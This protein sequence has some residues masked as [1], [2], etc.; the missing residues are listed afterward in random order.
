M[1]GL[2]RAAPTR[3][4][5]RARRPAPGR[6]AVRHQFQILMVAVAAPPGLLRPRRDRPP[7]HH[8]RDRRDSAR[9][10]VDRL[11]PCPRRAPAGPSPRGGGDHRHPRRDVRRRH[12]RLP[13]RADVRPLASWRRGSPPTRRSRAS[14]SAVVVGDRA[15]SGSP[16]ST[17]TGCTRAMPSCSGSAWRSPHRSATCSSPTSSGRPG[18]R[19]PAACSGPHGGALDRL[20]AALFAVVVGYYCWHAML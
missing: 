11:R 16:A 2:R 5:A 10:L 6:G 9:R 20:D 15:R 8:D 3:R 1:F 12:R 18:P 7:R 13:R 14:R 4:P 17:R 19:T